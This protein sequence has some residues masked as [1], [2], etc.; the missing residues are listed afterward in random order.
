L[1]WLV[2]PFVVAPKHLPWQKKKEM[3][4]GASLFLL[5]GREGKDNKDIKDVK[6]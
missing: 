5:W 2:W 6:D 4:F 1:A 3:H